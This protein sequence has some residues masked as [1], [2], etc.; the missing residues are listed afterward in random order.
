[1]IIQENFCSLCRIGRDGGGMVQTLKRVLSPALVT[2][3]LLGVSNWS[4][5]AQCQEVPVNPIFASSLG[6]D[7]HR[8]LESLG[9]W[10]EMY[11]LASAMT[12]FIAFI[13]LV[14]QRHWVPSALLLVTSMVTAVIGLAAPGLCILADT[15]WSSD[16]A[17]RFTY[18]SAIKALA[19]ISW[20]VFWL[21]PVAIA[22]LRKQSKKF[23]ICSLVG[24]LVSAV[25]PL[26]W[27]VA[28]HFAF[29]RSKGISNSGQ[30]A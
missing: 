6:N 16:D 17:T 26:V 22:L 30:S 10:G 9:Y 13:V 23:M 28:I 27:V 15:E 24:G 5:A 2:L 29:W 8:W 25:I 19:L 1:L 3:F 18:I 20:L 21:S 7:P 4:S 14:V 11:L 12:M